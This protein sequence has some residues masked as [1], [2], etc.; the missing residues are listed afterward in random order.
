MQIFSLK[1]SELAALVTEVLTMKLQCV[2][3]DHCRLW[4][5]RIYSVLSGAK[6]QI[7]I[8]VLES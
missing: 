1:K 4:Y 2:A 7:W 6:E 5:E 3:S 8:D